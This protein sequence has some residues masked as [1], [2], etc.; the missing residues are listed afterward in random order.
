MSQRDD[1]EALG[2]LPVMLPALEG[3]PRASVPLR[4]LVRFGLADGLNQISRE[5][6]KRSV[7]VQANVRGRDLGSFVREARARVEAVPLPT[8]SWLAWGGQYENLKAASERIAV[9]VPVCFVLIFALLYLAL[10]GLAPALAVF[11]AVPLGLA[12]G[13]FALALTGTAFSV[14][15]AVGFICLAG[16]AVLNGTGGDEQHPGA[17]EGGA[18]PGRRGRRRRA[19]A[20]PAGADDGPRP[21]RRLQSRWPSPT[22]PEPRCR[23]PWPW[24]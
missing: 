17:A 2:A 7:V 6:G 10:G 13:A 3:R 16:V 9:V 12:G 19:G 15:A 14:S 23:S 20:D 5:N 24:W 8:G 4:A 21:R 1:V 18:G 11:A 22:G